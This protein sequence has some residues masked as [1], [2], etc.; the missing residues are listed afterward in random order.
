MKVR[1]SQ[2]CCG[3]CSLLVGVEATCLITLLSEIIAIAAC[4]SAVPVQILGLVVPPYAQVLAA[5]W[6]FV[7]IPVVITAG[8]GALYR[9]EQSL[10]IFFVY[11]LI[12]FFLGLIVP[13]C[14]LLSGSLCDVVVDP[15]VQKMGSAFVC[16]FTD[17]FVFMWTLIAAVCNL[18]IVYIVWSAAE[19]ISQAPYPELM[20]YT[21][22]LRSVQAPSPLAGPYPLSGNRA[23]PARGNSMGHSAPQSGPQGMGPSS[24]APGGGVT[25]PGSG[26]LGGQRGFAP[27]DVSSA[28]VG[29]PVGTPQSFIPAPSSGARF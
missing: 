13:I 2:T 27:W 1:P 10:R 21:D 29:E 18:Y 3:C 8:V 19:E 24:Y 7:G 5:S 11:L 26:P 15:T 28:A 6:A 20:R 25:M 16:G 4:S 22:A 12:S 14:F 17:T 23:E 9:I